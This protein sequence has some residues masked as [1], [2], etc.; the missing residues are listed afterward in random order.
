[1][2]YDIKIKTESRL[3]CIELFQLL[4]EILPFWIEVEVKDEKI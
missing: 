4:S 1:M 2:K 3:N